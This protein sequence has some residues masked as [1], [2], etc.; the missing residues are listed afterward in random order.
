MTTVAQ[1]AQAYWEFVKLRKPEGP[2]A[3]HGRW[4][5]TARYSVQVGRKK[6]MK[7]VRVRQGGHDVGS[8]GKPVLHF[9]LVEFEKLFEPA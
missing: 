5:I 3:Y 1:Q 9:S 8:T 2:A 7:C 6:M 4:K